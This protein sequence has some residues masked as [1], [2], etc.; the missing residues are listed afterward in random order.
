MSSSFSSIKS[1]QQLNPGDAFRIKTWE[2]ARVKGGV[3]SNN[4]ATV[5][6]PTNLAVVSS[7]SYVG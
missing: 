4:C 2:F 5:F 6:S 1:V 3:E 7:E